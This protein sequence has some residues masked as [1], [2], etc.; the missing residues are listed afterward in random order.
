MVNT[1]R[2]IE[3]LLVIFIYLLPFL[4]IPTTLFGWEAGKKSEEKLEGNTDFDLS[5]KEGNISLSAKDASLKEV[6]KEIGQRIK[7]EVVGNIP[8][9]EKVSVKFDKLS[10]V[11]ALEKLGINYGYLMGSERGEKKIFKIFALP[12]GKETIPSTFSTRESNN[13]SGGGG[14]GGG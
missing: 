4:V 8:E 12:R 10:I 11:A 6:L 14:R 2:K 7:V 3:R 13:I 9:G 1:R 5:I